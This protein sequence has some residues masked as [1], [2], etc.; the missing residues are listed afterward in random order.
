MIFLA[1]SDEM[2]RI[3]RQAVE[4][5]IPVSILMENAGRA[6]ADRA[7]EIAAKASEGAPVVLAGPGQNGGD[8]LCLSLIHI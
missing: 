2:R 7:S 4:S 6:L 1:R 5:G 3:D 8:G